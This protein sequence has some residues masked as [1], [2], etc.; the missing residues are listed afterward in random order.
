MNP[1]YLIILFL[2][3]WTGNNV[4]SVAVVS[5]A[6][7]QAANQL[8]ASYQ[9]ESDGYLQPDSSTTSPTKLYPVTKY[10][11]LNSGFMGGD[12][13]GL[14]VDYEPL[15]S[16]NYGLD[17]GYGIGPS[18]GLNSVSNYES[19][20]GTADAYS[21]STYGLSPYSNP[22]SAYGLG[23][24]NY[25][26]VASYGTRNV[27]SGYRNYDTSPVDNSYNREAYPRNQPLY[28]PT[29][30]SDLGKSVLLTEGLSVNLLC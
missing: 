5:K 29:P 22:L 13:Y 30:C 19:N 24:S 20:Y 11:N 26:T 17:S 6:A 2:V 1:V 10:T 14:R 23:G 15:S 9:T 25:P 27:N 3:I 7:L 12:T 28:V 18:F 8:V 21:G 16:A 4:H